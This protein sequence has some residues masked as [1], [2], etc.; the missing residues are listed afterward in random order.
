MKRFWEVRTSPETF[1]LRN[2]NVTHNEFRWSELFPTKAQ[3]AMD[4]GMVVVENRDSKVKVPLIGL[5]S[6]P[7]DLDIQEMRQMI[8]RANKGIRMATVFAVL[9]GVLKHLYRDPLQDMRDRKCKEVTRPWS[10]NNL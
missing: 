7:E 9:E 8:K 10:S 5:I 4:T 6:S 1:H 3:R 2:S